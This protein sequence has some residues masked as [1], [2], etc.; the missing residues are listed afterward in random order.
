MVGAQRARPVAEVGLQP[1]QRPVAGLLQ[2]QQPDPAPGRLHR[3]GQVTA[4][5]PRAGQQVAQVRA[6]ALELGPEVQ[7]PVVVQA[8][9]QVAAVLGHGLRGVGGDRGVVAGRGGGPGRLPLGGEHPQVDPAGAGVPPAQVPRRDHQRRLAAQ[10]LAQ[11]MQLAAEVREGL[12]LGGLGPEQARD[13]LPGLR[14]A[15]MG[16]QVRDEG[17]GAGRPGR[18]AGAVVGDDLL[19]QE[20]HVQHVDTASWLQGKRKVTSGAPAREPSSGNQGAAGGVEG[21]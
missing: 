18:R 3:P 4:P 19:P 7:Q 14:A 16:G 8:G 20:G 11:V 15:R 1:H 10:H 9:Q 17:Y 6:L 13:E 21:A 2:R 12:G 5:G